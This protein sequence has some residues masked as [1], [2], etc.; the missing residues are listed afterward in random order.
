MKQRQIHD[1]VDS[2]LLGRISPEN[3]KLLHEM[4]EADPAFAREIKE[5]EEA[6]RILQLAR[7]REL[8]QKLL[9]W[10]ALSALRN[11]RKKK[12]LLILLVMILL[13]FSS[14]CWMTYYFSPVHL[15]KQ[16][17]NSLQNVYHP[18][19]ESPLIKAKWN[20]G[21]KAFNNED[22]ENAMLIFM[23]L[24]ENNDSSMKYYCDWNILLCRLALDGPTPGWEEDVIAFLKRAPGPIQLSAEHLLKT[25]RSPLYTR[26][27][28]SLLKKGVSSVKPKII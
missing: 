25:I 2:Y 17:F 21:T 15:A 20:A 1:L 12:G 10:D 11:G 9:T 13:C 24:T 22:F 4:M 28:R 8:R 27:Y 14:W 26:L 18:L 7:Q 3:K 5:S 19:L 16:S 6:F 23:S